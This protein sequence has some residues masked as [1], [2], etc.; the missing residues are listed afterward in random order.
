MEKKS[1]DYGAKDTIE[2]IVWFETLDDVLQEWFDF[3]RG[4]LVRGGYW[5]GK[6]RC[7]ER[8]ER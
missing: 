1:A 6:E 5:C 4:E 3:R 8:G 7:R 2:L